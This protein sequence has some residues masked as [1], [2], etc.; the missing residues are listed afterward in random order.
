MQWKD[1]ENQV[2]FDF[3]GNDLQK[4]YNVS[5]RANE[6]SLSCLCF[7]IIQLL[8]EYGYRYKEIHINDKEA[9]QYHLCVYEKK[10]NTLLIFKEL[11][12]CPLWKLKER[13]SY[14]V[15]AIMKKFGAKSCK[16][17]YFV[18]DN[19]YLQIIGHNDDQNDPGRGYNFYSLKWFF[20]TYFG[21]EEYNRFKSA[22]SSY[23]RDV[24]NCIG[25]ITVKTLTP[26]SLINFRKVTKNEV[27][28]YSYDKL[29][30]IKANS[31]DLDKNEFEKLKTQFLRIKHT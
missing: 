3:V 31:F 18:Y 28:K 22:L 17:V 20:E 19:A 13:E 7:I 9:E 1:V 27:L 4:Y 2:I 24:R 23:L 29:L 14:L 30:G 12:E 5:K 25:Y 21:E 16:Y 26:G 11:E 15:E 6:I 8:K 10:N